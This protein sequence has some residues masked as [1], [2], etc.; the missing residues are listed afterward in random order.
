MVEKKLAKK[1][2]YTQ[3]AMRLAQGINVEHHVVTSTQSADA[4]QQSSIMTI[5][6]KMKQFD[7]ARREHRQ[8]QLEVRS[9]RLRCYFAR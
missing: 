5:Q 1:L 2:I 6:Q 8:Q 7:T 3:K 9:T 4:D